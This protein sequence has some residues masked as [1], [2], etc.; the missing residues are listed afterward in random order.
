M[1]AILASSDNA[2]STIQRCPHDQQNPYT[3][4]HNGLIRDG[5]I[6]PDCRWLL[7]YLLSN[8]GNWVISVAQIINHLKPHMAKQKVYNIVNEAIESGY[9]K[10]ETIR[11]GNRVKKIQYYVSETPKFKKC[12]L[13]P[14]FEEEEARVQENADNKKEQKNKKEQGLIISS[15]SKPSSS[16]KDPGKV[17][18]IDDASGGDDLNKPLFSSSQGAADSSDIVVTKTNGQELRVTQ[19][20]VFQFF[21]NH[22]KYS[23]EEIQEAIRRFRELDSR[24]VNNVLGYLIKICETIKKEGLKPNRKKNKT[25]TPRPDYSKIP[26]CG[27]PV[28]LVEIGMEAYEKYMENERKKREKGYL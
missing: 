1:S 14:T 28:K 15:S 7:I 23:T 2:G 17:E 19:S 18:T 4:I 24:K 22:P 20:E 11:E 26:P 8:S 27:P 10:R 25:E 9:M 3:M 13:L 16:T 12:F 5:S 21:L 6:S